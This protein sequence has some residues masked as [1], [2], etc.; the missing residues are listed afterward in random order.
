MVISYIRSLFQKSGMVISYIRSLFQKSTPI[1]PHIPPQRGGGY[2]GTL[3]DWPIG[4]P[5]RL[6]PIEI[7]ADWPIGAG[8]LGPID[9]R[10]ASQGQLFDDCLTLQVVPVDPNIP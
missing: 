4:H 9:C 6:E 1:S 7:L 3:A 5:S 10:A 8:R 2:G